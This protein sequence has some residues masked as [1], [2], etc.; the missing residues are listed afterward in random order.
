VPECKYGPGAA[1]HPQAMCGSPPR[2]SGDRETPDGDLNLT[3]GT[4]QPLLSEPE[5][6]SLRELG[7]RW[8]QAIQEAP[9]PVPALHLSTEEPDAQRFQQAWDQWGAHV[10]LEVV[11]SPYR[12]V[13]GP[14]VNYIEALHAQRPD[15]ML[16]IVLPVIKAR[17]PWQRPLHSHLG[18]H[19]RRTPGAPPR[20]RRRGGALPPARLASNWAQDPGEADP[21][22]R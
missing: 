18:D 6:R 16:T 19:L 4:T 22:R 10:P 20:H 12:A 21:W 13:A 3:A 15:L 1:S 11:V 14:I 9:P 8:Q 7:R 17:R 5:F 2:F